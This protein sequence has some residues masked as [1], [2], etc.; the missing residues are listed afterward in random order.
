MLP[1]VLASQSPRRRELLAALGVACEVIP[2]LADET[3][4]PGM[5][6]A[7]ALEEVAARKG[8]AVWAHLGSVRWVLAADTGVVVDERVLGKPNDRAHAE[9]MLRTLEGRTH[10]V[11]TAVA[12]LGPDCARSLFVETEVTFRRLTAEHI[13]WYASLEEPYDKA[14]GYAIQGHGAFLVESICGSFTNVVGLPM[15]EVSRLLEEYGLTPW[16]QR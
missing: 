8:R 9:E 11:I 15:A 14:G 2:S 16:R 4:P 13:S 3:L 7:K 10:R 6:I 5:P 12:L 1:L